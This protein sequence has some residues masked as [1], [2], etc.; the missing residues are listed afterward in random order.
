[1]EV[2]LDEAAT[3]GTNNDVVKVNLPDKEVKGI[4]PAFGEKYYYSTK[5]DDLNTELVS[6]EF[7]LTTATTATFDYKTLYDVEF[8]YDYLTVT[9]VTDS[10]EEVVLDVIGDDDTNGDQSAETTNGQWEDKS[11]DLSQ[12]AGKKVTLH[13]NYVT[14]G[15]LALDGFALDNASLTVDGNVVFTDDAEGD[16][17]LKQKA[18]LFQTVST[19]KS[20]ITYW[21]GEATT[22]QMK[23]LQTLAVVQA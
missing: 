18:L 20:I 22:V 8:D 14:D 5:G 7:D 11:Y 1:M 2:L 10:G 19:I 21:N 15:G 3:K 17:N 12:F 4:Q 9:A 16:D 23:V 13:F 6:P